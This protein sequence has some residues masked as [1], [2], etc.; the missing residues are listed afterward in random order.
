MYKRGRHIG[1][2]LQKLGEIYPC[3]LG[4]STEDPPFSQA[5]ENLRES[6]EPSLLQKTC[7]PFARISLRASLK[8]LVLFATSSPTCSTYSFQDF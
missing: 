4:D 3:P 2:P 5:W 8:K 7:S 1:R 6:R